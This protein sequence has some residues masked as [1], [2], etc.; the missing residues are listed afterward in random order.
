[1]AW[2]GKFWRIFTSHKH[3][4]WEPNM[5]VIQEILNEFYHDT[6][7]FAPVKLQLGVSL[8]WAWKKYLHSMTDRE[9]KNRAKKKS[10][11]LGNESSLEVKR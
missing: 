9:D 11:S 8:V 6:T 4:G 3:I 1:M 7:G 5:K 10:F 2:V